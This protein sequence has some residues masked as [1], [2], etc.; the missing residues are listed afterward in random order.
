L[1]LGLGLAGEER[2]VLLVAESRGQLLHVGYLT[3]LGL[4]L[5]LGLGVGLG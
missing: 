4:G 3:W 1:G 5:G 2:L